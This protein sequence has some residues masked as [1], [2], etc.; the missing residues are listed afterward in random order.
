MGPLFRVTTEPFQAVRMTEPARL[1]SPELAKAQKRRILLRR[2]LL[3]LRHQTGGHPPVSM[4]DR[5][6][7]N[8]EKEN[9]SRY[10]AERGSFEMRVWRGD[11]TFMPPLVMTIITQYPEIHFEYTGGFLYVPPRAAP[12]G[13]SL[14]LLC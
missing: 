12:K 11:L 7:I 6:K 14:D 13:Q 1:L 9:A 5:A 10:L 3:G 2:T 4:K 8:L